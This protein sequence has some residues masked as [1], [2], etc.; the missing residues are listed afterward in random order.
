MKIL[1]T[2]EEFDNAG[3][4]DKLKLK[5]Y[6]CYKEFK[7]AKKFIKL[8]LENYTNKKG[9][10]YST[11]CRFCSRK[12]TSNF[13][14]ISNTQIVNC[15]NCATEFRKLNSEIKKY[16]NHFCCRSCSGTYN[17]T[18]KS[19]GTRRS[20][21]EKYLEDQLTT[22][23]PNL[24]FD[25]NKKDAINSELDIYIPSLKLAIELNGIYHYEPIHGQDKLNQI[26]NN[27]QRKFQACLENNIELLLIDTS[28]FGYFKTEQANKFLSII[29]KII[30][31]KLSH[32]INNSKNK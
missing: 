5:C 21:L 17:N 16:P 9:I 24:I 28:S 2:Q 25:F 15:K 31:Q 18:H 11:S 23:Y 1:Y 4:D 14:T 22:L 6:Q 30:D 20:K 27:D 13:Q 3:S 7:T 10:S 29:T 19:H 26:Q 12:C 32:T 8:V